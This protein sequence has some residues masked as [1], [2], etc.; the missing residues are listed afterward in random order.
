MQAKKLI[1][2]CVAIAAIGLVS[3]NSLATA[4]ASVNIVKNNSEATCNSIQPAQDTTIKKNK[5]TQG[6]GNKIATTNMKISSGVRKP[7]G[8]VRKPGGGVRKPGGGVRKPG[9]GVRKPGGNIVKP[10]AGDSIEAPKQ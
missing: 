7:G 1:F 3:Q 10:N 2:T 9:G 5:I 4:K 6:G 8:G